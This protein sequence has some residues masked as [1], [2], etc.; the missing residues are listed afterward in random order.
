MPSYEPL[1]DAQRK[2]R[3]MSEKGSSGKGGPKTP[4]PPSGVASK[5]AKPGASAGAKSGAQLPAEL[6]ALQEQ[7]RSTRK[8]G[9][10]TAFKSKKRDAAQKPSKEI[11][12]D[13]I[14]KF[15]RGEI[16]LAQLEGLS[17]DQ[18]Y[19]FAEMGYTMFKSGKLDD[20]CKVF[21]GLVTY[22]PYDGYFHSALGAIYQKQK[23]YEDAIR[24][25]NLALKFNPHDTCSLTNRGETFLTLG[26]LQEAADDFKKAIDNDPDEKDPWSMRSR[27]LVIAVTNALKGREAK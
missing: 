8:E 26:R 24:Q 16:T 7:E 21:E 18:L 10:V 12:L 14:R 15:V 27:A 25:Y 6:R 1:Q 3:S 11:T 22:N 2:E 4:A 20:A 13:D 17:R 5:G 19:D 23:R 9:S